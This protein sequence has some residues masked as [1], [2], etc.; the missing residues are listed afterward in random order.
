MYYIIQ[1][2]FPEQKV[3]SRFI[4]NIESAC[5]NG[6]FQYLSHEAMLWEIENEEIF[7]H[8]EFYY[9]EHHVPI[10]SRSLWESALSIIDTDGVF[11]IPLTIEYCGECRHFMIAI[12]ARI[13]CFG[14]NRRISPLYAGRYDYFRSDDIDDDNLYVSE[15]LKLLWTNCSSLKYIGAD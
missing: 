2:A 9:I 6:E 4:R 8:R 1:N 10:F 12:P 7:D 15:R 14:R 3:L 13:R 11:Q 5:A